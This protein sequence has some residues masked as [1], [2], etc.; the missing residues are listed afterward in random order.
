MRVLH[1]RREHGLTWEVFA[2]PHAIPP[3]EYLRSATTVNRVLA[4]VPSF[5][6]YA[7][8]PLRRM[9]RNF[10]TSLTGD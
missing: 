9:N 3:L 1:Q 4:A 6:E 7:A 2:P 8:V 10:V 5:Y